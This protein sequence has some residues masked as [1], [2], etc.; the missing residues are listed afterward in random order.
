MATSDEETIITF[1]ANPFLRCNACGKR[2]V[3]MVGSQNQVVNLLTGLVT[4]SLPSSG[5]NWP[6]FDVSAR[7]SVCDGWTSTAGCPHPMEQR[8]QHSNSL[9]FEGVRR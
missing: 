1:F 3:G 8:A 4:V 5:R 6:C 2:A 9:T 7:T